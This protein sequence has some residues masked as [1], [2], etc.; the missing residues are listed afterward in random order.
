MTAIELLESLNFLDEHERIEAK[1]ASEVGKS[2]LETVCAFSNEPGLGGGWIVLGV[3]REEMA[4]FPSYQ[5]E[6]IASP[7]KITAD[8]ASQCRD[9]FNVPVRVDI[10]TESVNGHNVIVVF[11]PEAQS[12]DKP[13][14]FKAQGLPKGAFRRIGSTD[15][16]CTDDDMA[17]FYQGRKQESFDSGIVADATVEDLSADA[18]DE[19]ALRVLLGVAR[20]GVACA[21][22]PMGTHRSA[23][24]REAQGSRPVSFRQSGDD[25]GGAALVP[26]S[27]RSPNPHFQ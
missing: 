26:P 13:V 3:V 16:R 7:D 4:L 17:V 1:R 6:G 11:V 2:V 12:Q 27:I 10:S 19:R 22:S 21:V 24:R 8:L 20:L 25:G 5:I 15:Q 14:F 18:V 9:I 23:I